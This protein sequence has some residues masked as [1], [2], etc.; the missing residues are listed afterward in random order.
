MMA[1][2]LLP[3]C[4][5]LAAASLLVP[6]TTL[7]ENGRPYFQPHEQF[8]AAVEN[9]STSPSFVF[10]TIV[11]GR[12]G[13]SKSG[14]LLAVFILGATH[15]ERHIDYS[16]AGTAAVQAIVMSQRDHRFVFSNPRAL[17]N[18]GFDHLETINADACRIIRGGHPAY[19]R[20][21]T[22]QTVEGQP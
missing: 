10:A 4:R 18:V 9:G 8:V 14:C 16:D 2:R 21:V 22:H 12:S 15:L 5:V 17:W 1:Q 7:A 11:D 6:A 13:T 3:A 19:L 20:D